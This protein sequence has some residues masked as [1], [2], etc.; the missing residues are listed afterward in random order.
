[1]VVLNKYDAVR[2]ASLAAVGVAHVFDNSKLA[3]ALHWE[4]LATV[5][6]S[7]RSASWR[8][9][10]SSGHSSGAD[11]PLTLLLMTWR[12]SGVLSMQCQLVPQATKENPNAHQVADGVQQLD[13]RDCVL[14]VRT[15]Q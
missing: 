5:S 8:S 1:M 2:M 14:H 15:V 9:A 4:A 10:R 13:K 12:I 6:S 7:G 3:P 11:E